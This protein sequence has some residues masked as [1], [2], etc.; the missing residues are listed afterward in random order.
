MGAKDGAVMADN[1][2]GRVLF[3]SELKPQ[4]RQML[5]Q[6]RFCAAQHEFAGSVLS[7]SGQNDRQN[8]GQLG[9]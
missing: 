9:V 2:H 5:R 7:N 6:I 1:S 4:G 8:P 3:K